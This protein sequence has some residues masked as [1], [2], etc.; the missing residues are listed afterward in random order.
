MTEEQTVPA[1]LVGE[2]QGL[3]EQLR[4]ADQ[5]GVAGRAVVKRIED[6]LLEIGSNAD[7]RQLAGSEV[8]QAFVERFN[9]ARQTTSDVKPG[10]IMNPGSILQTKRPWTWDDLKGCDTVTFIPNET[11]PITWNGLTVYVNTDIETTIPAVHYG[12]YQEHRRLMRAGR[13][14]AEYLA[15][16]RTTVS[17]PS[18]ISTDSVRIRGSASAGH[19]IP[20]GGLISRGTTS[21]EEEG[22]EQA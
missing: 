6:I 17:D 15:G 11:L 3:V 5:R 19:F 8:I 12:I 14:H 20:G 13:E 1:D 9:D 18:I 7:Y 21:E 16:Q 10:Q 2:L 4:E 22:G